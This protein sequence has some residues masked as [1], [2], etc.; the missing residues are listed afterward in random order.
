MPPPG[1]ADSGGF[2]V[3]YDVYDRFD[4]GSPDNPTLY[5]TETGLRTIA[6]TFDNAA[7]ALHV[8]V[9]LNHAGFSDQSTPGFVESGGYPGLAITLPNNIDG[10]SVSYTHLTLPTKA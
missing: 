10:D 6:D 7:I 8:D 4:L 9:I 3:G 1:R 5:G 2:S